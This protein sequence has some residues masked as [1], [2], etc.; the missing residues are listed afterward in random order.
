MAALLAGVADEREKTGAWMRRF[1]VFGDFPTRL[2]R[3]GLLVAPWFLEPFLIA[4]WTLLFFAMAGEQRRAVRGNLSALLPGSGRIANFLRSYRVFLEFAFTYVDA[5]RCEKA[6][7]K[8]DWAI[9]GVENFKDLAAR[10]EGCLIVTAHMG[11][12]DLAAPVFSGEFGRTV[13]AVRAPERDPDMQKL[14]EEELRRWESRHPGFRT[15]YNRPGEMLGVELARILAGGDVVAVQA[16]RVMFD[17]SFVE[18]GIGGGWLWRLPRGPMV[19]AQATGAPCFPLFITRDG[20]R[21]YRVCVMPELKLPNRRRGG[22]DEGLRIW[23]DTLL[24][25]VRGNWPQWFVF[26]PVFR[27]E[28]EA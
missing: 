9:D 5:V 7:G 18:V 20:L 28:D 15:H 11:N 26:E 17:V 1:G 19:L 27:K 2:L 12:Y 22:G 6:G 16:D 8:V 24:A 3:G 25:V 13:H 4:L 23:T 10:R 21:R 14:R